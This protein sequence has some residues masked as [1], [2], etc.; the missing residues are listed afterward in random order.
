M[1]RSEQPTIPETPV[2]RPRVWRGVDISAWQDPA[3][4]D[5]VAL[6]EL[7]DF[8]CVRFTC[9][10]RRDSRVEQHVELI[11]RHALCLDGYHFFRPHQPPAAQFEAFCAVDEAVGYEPGDL[12]PWLDIEH[13]PGAP[14][15]WRDVSSAWSPA[16][17]ELC[18]LLVERYGECLP[19][20]NQADFLALGSP[21]WVI[22]R[23]IAVANWTDRPQPT[24][25]QGATWSMWQHAV[26]PLDGV[27]TRPIDQDIA[28]RLIHVPHPGPLGLTRGELRK[29]MG[30]VALTASQSLADF[31]RSNRP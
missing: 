19:Y 14:P 2:P 9:G 31:F 16:A 29:V 3:G 25:P 6:S 11:R 12:C 13:D 8:V 18:R 7:C 20:L 5:W 21:E 24:T 23:P 10:I 15:E 28:R 27:S 4:I 1:S 22:Q 26:R 30:D 17:Y